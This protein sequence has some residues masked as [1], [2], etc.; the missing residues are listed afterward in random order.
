MI[1]CRSCNEEKD[2]TSFYFR[3]DSG[4]FRSE[5]KMC[6][7]VKTDLRRRNDMEKAREYT[8]KYGRRVY[9]ENPEKYR[10]KARIARQKN[11]EKARERVNKSYKKIYTTRYARE[12]A[13]L[14]QLSASRRSATP[15]WLTAIHKAMIQEFYDIAKARQTQTGIV[16]HVDHIVPIN[17]K[18]VCGLHVPWNLQI[19]SRRENCSKKNNLVGV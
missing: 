7:N 1:I 4:K 13:R 18:V 6:W 16:Y 5:C 2:E 9:S 8:R 3:K 11:P 19:L 14:N 15:E 12:R 10:E 17:G